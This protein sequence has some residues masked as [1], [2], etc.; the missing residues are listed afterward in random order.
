MEYKSY[1]EIHEWES[2]K[3]L[4]VLLNKMVNEGWRA[5]SHKLGSKTNEEA[6]WTI[7]SKTTKLKVG[8]LD[9]KMPVSQLYTLINQSYKFK[10]IDDFINHLDKGIK[11]VCA[12][13]QQEQEF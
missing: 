12:P 6:G 2:I 4:E 9:C 3:Q 11:E 5:D 1:Y 10:T 7:F 8:L 13:Q